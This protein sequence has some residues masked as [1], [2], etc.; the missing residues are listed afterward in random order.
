MSPFEHGEVFV[1]DD[2]GEVWCSESFAPACTLGIGAGFHGRLLALLV[3]MLS[4]T[5]SRVESLTATCA[6]GP[7]SGQLRALPGHYAREGQQHHHR[8]SL[9]SESHASVQQRH[10][11]SCSVPCH[12][13]VAN[14]AAQVPAALVMTPSLLLCCS[15]SSNGSGGATTWGR[16]CR[17]CRTSPMPSRCAGTIQQQCKRGS[18]VHGC[19]CDRRRQG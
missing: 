9:P 15:R 11:T 4:L 19:C 13:Q 3:Q 12:L 10:G 5:S 8:E 1:L 6:G 17:W 16:R 14:K 2:G 18:R 7:G